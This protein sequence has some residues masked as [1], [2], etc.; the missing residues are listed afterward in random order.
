MSIFY[1]ECTS[2]LFWGKYWCQKLARR[3][4]VS[5]Y[6]CTEFSVFVSLRKSRVRWQNWFN[7]LLSDCFV[8]SKM[9]SILKWISGLREE[10]EFCFLVFYWYFL[11]FS[12]VRVVLVQVFFRFIRK[13]VFKLFYVTFT[14]DIRVLIQPFFL[15][16]NENKCAK[17]AQQINSQVTFKDFKINNGF[18]TFLSFR[19]VAIS[20]EICIFF[21]CRSPDSFWGTLKD[22]YEHETFLQNL[23][24][25]TFNAPI[26]ASD[27]LTEIPHVCYKGEY[28]Y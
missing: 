22:M 25:F 20:N 16:F 14:I 15:D 6:I 1:S 17:I 3:G 10:T 24:Q 4:Y 19:T 18:P 13:I 2:F 9:C 11:C 5:D 7:A 28:F 12:H 23:M 27:Q 26:N 21:T 8:I